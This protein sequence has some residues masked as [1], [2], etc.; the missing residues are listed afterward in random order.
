MKYIL[1]YKNDQVPSAADLA[2]VRSAEGLEVI[3]ETR[4][5]LLVE[6]EA[7]RIDE[8]ERKFENWEFSPQVIYKPPTTR[9]E[10]KHFG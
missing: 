5:S 8:L 9:K 4:T 2:L 6:V 7:N 3:G 1:H 10:V